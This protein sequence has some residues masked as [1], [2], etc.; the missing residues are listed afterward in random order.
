MLINAHPRPLS[1]R[2]T[3]AP[4]RIPLQ[5]HHRALVEM[6]SSEFNSL[7]GAGASAPPP[8]SMA[9]G[10]PSDG[11]CDWDTTTLEGIFQDG[12]E[13][14]VCDYHMLGLDAC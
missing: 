7:S 9:G 12:G 6:S 3:H 4:Y 14:S 11:C 1:V 2:T 5:H 13:F 10:V 8:S